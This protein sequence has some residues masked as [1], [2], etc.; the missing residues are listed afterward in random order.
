MKYLSLKNL[1]CGRKYCFISCIKPNCFFYLYLLYFYFYPVV[2]PPEYLDWLVC[3]VHSQSMLFFS[4]N[5]LIS[6]IKPKLIFL[7]VLILV[8]CSY[9]PLNKFVFMS[10]CIHW[11]FM[12]TAVS[13]IAS[14]LSPFLICNIAILKKDLAASLLGH[15]SCWAGLAVF[16]V[17]ISWIHAAIFSQCSP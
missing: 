16:L 12:K 15:S 5:T 14:V 13:L 17:F 9:V 6:C 1:F 8:L 10:M 3:K 11:N 7:L 4:I 2:T